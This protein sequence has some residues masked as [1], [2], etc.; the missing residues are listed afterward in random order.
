MPKKKTRRSRVCNCYY[1]QADRE[2]L[3]RLIREN[4]FFIDRWHNRKLQEL[5]KKILQLAMFIDIQNA[6]RKGAN[7]DA[8][9]GN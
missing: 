2:E 3:G 4:R 5:S 6:K 7:R 8:K 9:K 1:C